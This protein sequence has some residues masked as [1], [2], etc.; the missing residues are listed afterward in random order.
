MTISRNVSILAQGASTAGV[1]N[2]SY[3]GSLAW[4]SV[5]TGN[6]TAVAGN[7]YPV[8]TTSG[9]VTVTLPASATIGQVVQ[10]ADYANK[11]GTNACNVNPNGLKIR[12]STSSVSLG[13]NGES[14]SIV[15]IDSTQ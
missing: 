4:Q 12:G 10:I 11:F 9:A 15:Y 8:N 3:G 5:Q 1:L 14:V 7:A 13:I 6:F 2:A